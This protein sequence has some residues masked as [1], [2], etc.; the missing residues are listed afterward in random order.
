MI[1][2]ASVLLCAFFPDERQAQAQRLVREHV[3]D[4]VHL[5]AP[6]LLSFELSNALWQAERRARISRHQTEEIFQAFVGLDI[7]IILD[8]CS[9]RECFEGDMLPL[10]RR[11]NCSTYDAAYLALAQGCREPLITADARL[12]N[13]VHVD[14][15]WVIWVGDYPCG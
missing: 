1:V 11:F 2:D 5:K 6:A 3:A 9:L 13:S 7:Q 12:Y 8:T 14:L 15:D 10:A 4:R